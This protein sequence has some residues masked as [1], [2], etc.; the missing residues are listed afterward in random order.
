MFGFVVPRN[1]LVY[2]AIFLTSISVASTLYLILDLDQGM[3]GFIKISSQPLRDAI[4]H[5]DQSAPTPVA[6]ST[7][8]LP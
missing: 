5:M 6:A 4:V 8:I 2:L 3:S 1:G 7:Q